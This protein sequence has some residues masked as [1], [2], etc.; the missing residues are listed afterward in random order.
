[1]TNWIRDHGHYGG[2]VALGVVIVVA[3]AAGD[4]TMSSAFRDVSRHPVGRPLMIVSWFLITG[5]LFGVIPARYDV[6]VRA[7]DLLAD[8]SRSRKVKASLSRHAK[9]AGKSPL[10]G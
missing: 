6:L 2:W 8:D 10:R 9:R 1:M 5:H 4:R 7:T 3:D